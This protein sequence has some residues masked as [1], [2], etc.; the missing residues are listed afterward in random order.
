M[1]ITKFQNKYQDKGGIAKL[2]EMRAL[3]YKQDFIAKHFGVSRPRVRQWMLD[4]FLSV[5]DP[6]S[7]RETVV[8]ENMVE[9]AN[10]N[11]LEDFKKAFR[12]SDYYDKA[13]QIINK[14]QH[15]S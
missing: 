12:K 5:Y 4:F 7:D 13:L 6:R 10:N 3:F 2:T 11:G 9:F 15:D 14:E 8:I 1:L